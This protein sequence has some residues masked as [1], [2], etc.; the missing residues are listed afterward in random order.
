MTNPLLEI[1][2]N[3]NFAP[4]FDK[5]K[6]EHYLPAVKES[7]EIARAN[8]EKIKANTEAPSFE[9]TIVALEGTSELLGQATSIF[10]NQLSA[11]G[12]DDL[13]ELAQEI[14]PLSSAFSSD[15]IEDKDLFARIKAVYDRKD[16]LGLTPE[17]NML[18]EDTYKDFVRGGAL[19]EGS[20]KERLRDIKQELALLNPEFSN[21][22][23]KSSEAYMLVIE[24]E[25]DLAGLPDRI[26]D[27]AA[28]TAQEKDQPGKWIFTLDYPSFGPFL[29]FSEKRH[30]RED[31]WRAFSSRAWSESGD[32]E[33]DN[34]E[35]VLK[36][37]NLRHE[38]ANLLGYKTHAD[39]ILERRM[40]ENS[41]TVFEFLNKMKIAYK[42]AAQADFDELKEFTK[43]EHGFDD[44]K[45]WDI[46]FYAE[47]LKQKLYE[48][49]S[50]DL[51]PYFPLN[52]VLSGCFE[53]FAKLFGMKFTENKD[54]PVWHED[55]K[56]FD[57]TDKD[58]GEFI[59][60]LYGD[61]HPRT[62]K[63]SGAWKTA[64]RNQGLFN[65]KVERPVVAI[66][67]NFTKPTKDK[68]SLLSHGEVTTLF[69]EMGHAVHALLSKV[70]YRSL[71]GT[72]VLWDFVELPSQVQENWCYESE[73]LD[74]FAGHYETGEKIPAEL[75]EKLRK[76]KNFM[77]G[78][79]GLRQTALGTLD[80]AWHSADPSKI[81]DV[82]KF[83]DKTLL[84]VSFFPRFSGPISTSFT[85]IFAGG[86]SAG[87]YSYK[88]A[89]VLDA[90]TFELFLEKGLYDQETAQKYRHEILERGGA[91]HPKE[92]YHNFRGRDAD[93]EALLRREGLL[94]AA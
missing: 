18:L 50:E 49:S 27:M 13:Q 86:Y 70:T 21:N 69:H 16:R 58:T 52:K 38:K 60:T 10:Y 48:F 39:F 80:M 2:T 76:A 83:E 12:G 22:V 4:D 56:A 1:P 94:K 73:T 51:R 41:S 42:D 54:Y 65:G 91:A 29:Q 59:G 26:R 63:R 90:D 82:A 43:T 93:P 37:V 62:G 88:W 78:W 71:A 25:D 75:I 20:K 23:V 72:N 53:H 45:P 36:I 55:V 46:S 15:I 47:K 87:Y 89:E 40:A 6:T 30:L 11:I 81:K 85:H 64:Y 31:I 68:P 33:Y 61:F 9:N 32:G 66:V 19:L 74:K 28:T 84:D 17:E 57:V 3:K 34:N 77:N 7:I 5:I 79:G 92:L 44:L 8:I 24:N 67:C 14:A 35:N